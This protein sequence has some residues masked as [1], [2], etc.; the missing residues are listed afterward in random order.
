V[1]EH[2][3]HISISPL[4]AEDSLAN[5]IQMQQTFSQVCRFL[6]KSVFEV[7]LLGIPIQA[8]L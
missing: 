6:E 8:R 3:F 4:A 5:V 7:L 1:G 2:C